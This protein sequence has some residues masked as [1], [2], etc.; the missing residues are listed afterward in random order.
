MA[1]TVAAVKASYGQ[2]VNGLNSACSLLL[3]HIALDK[4][5]ADEKLFKSPPL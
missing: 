3:L 4:A 5:G 1:S 2:A